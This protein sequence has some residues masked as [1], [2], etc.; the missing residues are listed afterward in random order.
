MDILFLFSAV[1]LQII[2]T[3]I[4]IESTKHLVCDSLQY[5][6]TQYVSVWDWPY[7][8]GCV[9]SV[10]PASL[11]P[12]TQHWWYERGSSPGH[13]LEA[14]W[15]AVWLWS[16]EDGQV[17]QHS[18]QHASLETPG[19]PSTREAQIIELIKSR[20]TFDFLFLNKL[21][22]RTLLWKLSSGTNVF[23][24]MSLKSRRQQFK[25]KSNPGSL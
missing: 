6:Y 24:H 8:V 10:W 5:L 20:W 9:V 4:A 2:N 22:N 7:M 12:Q 3:F 23:S 14:S 1:H 21:N 19:Q 13:W 17:H 16:L 18:S 15:S 25:T 11:G